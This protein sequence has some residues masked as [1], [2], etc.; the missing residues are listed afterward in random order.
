MEGY[1]KKLEFGII[2]KVG[3]INKIEKST[4]RRPYVTLKDIKLLF[5]TKIN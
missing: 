2:D 5:G 1:E 4:K 3:H